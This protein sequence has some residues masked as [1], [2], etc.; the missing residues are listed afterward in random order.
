MSKHAAWFMFTVGFFLVAGGVGTIEQSVTDAALYDGILV[1][2]L[3]LMIM[4]CGSLGMRQLEA[5]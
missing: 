4:G 2:V 5:E 3:G 1:A